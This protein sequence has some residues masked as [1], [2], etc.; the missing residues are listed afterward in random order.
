MATPGD[1]L[2]QAGDDLTSKMEGL[3]ASMRF[4]IGNVDML[5]ERLKVSSKE[6]YSLVEASN[7]FE[8]SLSQNKDMMDKIVS[9]EMDLAKAKEI[10]RKSQEKRNKIL[11]QAENL[12]KKLDTM[13]QRGSRKQ[14]QDLKDQINL[15]VSKAKTEKKHMDTAVSTAQ[16]GQSKLSRG[17]SGIGRFLNNKVFQG[18]GKG[19]EGMAAGAR[20]AKVGM[21]GATGFMGKFMVLAKSFAR[22]N[23]FGLIIS[24]V[25]FIVK[26]VLQINQEVAQ[27]GRNLG[28][29]ADQARKVRQHFVNVAAD[30]AR[31]GIEY[32]DI[33]DAQQAL[34][35]SLGTSATMISGDILIGMAELTKRMKLSTEAAVGF[36][37]IALATRKTTEQIT[38]ATIEG[39]NAAAKD[40]GVRI[41][42]PKLLETVGR[43]SGRV[44]LIFADNMKLMGE[45]VASAQLLGLTMKDIEASQSSLLNFQTSIEKE[46]KAE[47]FLGRQINLERA[48]LAALTNDFKTLTEEITR[49]AGDYVDFMSMNA[50]QQNSIAEALGMSADQM[51][52]MLLQQADL[53]ALKQKA[54]EQGKDEIAANLSQMSVQEAFLASM[55]KLKIIVINMLGKI[56]DFELSR[57]MSALLGFGF[58]RTKLFDGMTEKMEGIGE[59]SSI[60]K[61]TSIYGDNQLT[62]QAIPITNDFS[63]G[64][65]KL[66][67]NPLDTFTLVG[68][69]AMDGRPANPPM[70]QENQMNSTFVVRQEKWDTVNFDF[71]TTKFSY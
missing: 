64:G 18:A 3:S 14:K 47:L 60:N 32:T 46:M 53:N 71:D 6:F 17:L 67:T 36:G 39:A 40:F 33:L 63:L 24:A 13:H 59:A 27:I 31:L 23:I 35:S 61:D 11:K 69:T 5:G 56:E 2:N 20:K 68:G 52:D 16:K 57:T 48:R 70:Q 7:Q 43:I 62:G 25:A 4:T 8:K 21:K 12:Q 10:A 55:E 41:E 28:I 42:F 19:F 9:G 66:R 37:K 1:K 51:A 22:A 38:K 65:L 58:K 15:L 49:E 54:L 26:A 50:L 44:R 30:A 34:N 29:S 45:T